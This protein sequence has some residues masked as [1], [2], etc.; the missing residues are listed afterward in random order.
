M[1]MGG[2]V[3]EGVLGELGVDMIKLQCIKYEVFKQNK[4]ILDL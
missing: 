3:V 1:R 2:C 4:F